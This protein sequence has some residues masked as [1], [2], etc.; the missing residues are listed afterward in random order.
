MMRI[1]TATPAL[2]ADV[3][4]HNMALVMA[5]V[6]E[7][8]PCARSDI[9]ARTGLVSGTVTTM[10]EELLARGLLVETGSAQGSRGR[11]RRLLRPA[12]DRVRTVA[13]E[14]FPA[15]VVGE[16]RD[17]SGRIL[18]TDT[19]SHRTALGDVDGYAAILATML[20]HAAEQA[21]DSPA[22]WLPDPVVVLPAIVRSDSG[23]VAALPLGLTDVD[24]RTP[25]L[26]ALRRLRGVTLTNDGRLSALAEYGALP[27]AALPRAMAYV[28]ARRDGVG[29]GLVVDGDL[30]SGSHGLGGL[31][32]HI[33]VDMT[34]PDCSCGARG[35]L[36]LH[37]SLPALLRRAGLDPAAEPTELVDR[38][39]AGDAS[40]HAALEVGGRALSTA[41]GTM[42]NYT[43]V[44]LVVLGGFLPPLLPW[45]EPHLTSLLGA[46]SRMVPRFA[47]RIALATYAMDAP[48]TG[49]WLQARS[50]VLE[51]PSKVPYL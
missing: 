17:L 12:P 31:V 42:S 24:L 26:R 2:S 4:R 47:P 36:E 45:L 10:V 23:I 32:G 38:L 14:L 11:P 43:D 37:L 22:T 35:C 29:G 1:M 21:A 15:S 28:A 5:A 9:R 46:R 20:D 51:N 3:G 27:R 48:R 6:V 34:G 41:I 39:H 49:A 50:S 44:D 33:S 7:N 13:V 19:R 8:E 18:W 16:V 30:Y 25:L 40:A